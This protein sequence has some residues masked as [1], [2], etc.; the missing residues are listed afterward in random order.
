MTSCFGRKAGESSSQLL[1]AKRALLTAFI[2]VQSLYTSVGSILTQHEVH[3]LYNTA[4]CNW[5][6]GKDL[7]LQIV[8][9]ASLNID[10]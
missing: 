6:A 9:I 7:D 5:T 4:S 10:I 2:L 3:V 8:V 1:L